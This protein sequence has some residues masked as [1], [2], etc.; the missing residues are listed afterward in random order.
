MSTLRSRLE[1]LLEPI[2]PKDHLNVDYSRARA[3]MSRRSA[4]ALIAVAALIATVIVA[5]TLW[6][7]EQSVS[8]PE[9]VEPIEATV[10]DTI[11]ASPP[12]SD[13]A[14]HTSPAATP[15]VIVV[16][17]VGLV[18]APG[19]VELPAGSRVVHAIEQAGGLAPEANPASVNLAA[20][21]T[22]GQQIV[23]GTQALPPSDPV[24]AG[25]AAPRDNTAEPTGPSGVTASG[26]INI[27][28]ATATE[29]EQLPGIGPATAAKIIAY[30]Q[31]NGPFG[32][33]A[34]L[35]EVPGIGPAKVTALQDAATV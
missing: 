3:G 28:T 31:Q 21:V 11:G 22:D 15:E 10:A 27:N 34:E 33:V 26:K 17:V 29:L 7:S 1:A 32:S 12:V 14:E 30:R 19:V 6:P 20:P 25:A 8:R 5:A 9:P 13:P 18:I 35:E 23:V 24:A 2:E 16:S 4:F